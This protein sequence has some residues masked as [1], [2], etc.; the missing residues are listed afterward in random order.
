MHPK[1]QMS[2]APS[3]WKITE[4]DSF[5]C[6]DYNLDTAVH[7]CISEEALIHL[8]SYKYSSVDR[9]LISRYFL[10]HYVPSLL[11]SQI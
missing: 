5:H 8:K 3:I 10:Q 6:I 11:L 7:D 9:S 4:A 2:Q 1:S